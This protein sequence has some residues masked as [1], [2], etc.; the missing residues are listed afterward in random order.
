M[1]CSL[2]QHPDAVRSHERRA[3]AHRS[4]RSTDASLQASPDL[5]RSL[6]REDASTVRLLARERVVSSAR[7]NDPH[8][9][10]SVPSVQASPIPLRIPVPPHVAP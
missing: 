1:P 5:L 2:L 6:R 10:P 9:P 4:H 7:L 3:A 8:H